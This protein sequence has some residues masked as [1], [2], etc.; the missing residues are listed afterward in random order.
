M[1]LDKKHRLPSTQ[2]QKVTQIFHSHRLTGRLYKAKQ[3]TRKLSKAASKISLRY[4]FGIWKRSL[5]SCPCIQPILFFHFNL[6]FFYFFSLSYYS[7][8]AA[9]YEE[10]EIIY[11]W[12]VLMGAFSLPSVTGI[13]P[14]GF[15]SILFIRLWKFILFFVCLKIF[16]KVINQ[17]WIFYTYWWFIFFFIPLI[18]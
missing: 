17:G 8:L 5:Q 1:L 11:P 4:S 2:W 18:W 9:W 3:N 10:Q 12:P 6:Y 15:I 13:A 16:F 7:G 14:E